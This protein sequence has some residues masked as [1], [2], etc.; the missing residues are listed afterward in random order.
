MSNLD[1]ALA[2]A[3]ERREPIA[4]KGFLVRGANASAHVGEF[5]HSLLHR[6]VCS[7]DLTICELL[8]DHGADIHAKSQFGASALHIAASRGFDSIC[9]LLLA[10]GSDVLAWDSH[11]MTA[12]DRAISRQQ[13]SCASII[14][15]TIAANAAR[16]VLQ[17]FS[18]IKP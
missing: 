15:S 3:I 12:L 5:G 8:L 10:R 6:A 11:G 16:S 2:D 17:E 9:A 1:L 7:G 4:C 18:A 13:E 14:R